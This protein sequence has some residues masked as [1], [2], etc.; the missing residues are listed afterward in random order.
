MSDNQ[1]LLERLVNLAQE[2]SGDKRRELLREVSD[3]FTA[4]SDTLTDQEVNAFGGVMGTIASDLGDDVRARL[5]QSICMVARAPHDLIKQL[6]KDEISVAEPVLSHSPV[7]TE[8]DLIEIAQS[9][10]QGHLMAMTNRDSLSSALSDVIVE[11]GNDDVLANLCQND[12]AQL[13]RAAMEIMTE[14]AEA[15]D[16]LQTPLV[17]RKDIPVDL[18]NDMYFFVS[19]A[20]REVI[21]KTNAQ[22][23]ETELSAAL[24]QSSNR[25]AKNIVKEEL[26]LVD[27][28]D[29][30]DKL[31]KYKE[32]NERRLVQLVKEHQFNEFIV[33]FSRLT[34]LEIKTVRKL[35][36]DVSCEGLALACRAVGFDHT[37]FASFVTQTRDMVDRDPVIAQQVIQLYGKIPVETAQRTIRFW[38]VRRQEARKDRSA[39]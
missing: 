39:A 20:L 19:S 26:A 25:I 18:L 30:V 4:E 5:S 22:L 32:L 8:T 11:R 31:E 17:K 35:L 28:I 14:R 27:A 3:L 33:A 16:K 1:M 34:D 6:A 15:S 37:S 9:K 29:Y 24:V 13:S 2:N 36:T 21:L 12:G 7:L 10:G 38:K 23:D